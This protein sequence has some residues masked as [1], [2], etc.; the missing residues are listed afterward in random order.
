MGV[1]RRAVDCVE[2]GYGGIGAVLMVNG[3]SSERKIE[4]Q[5]TF[6]ALGYLEDVRIHWHS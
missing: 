4:G 2:R 3:F 5:N 1:K 6:F